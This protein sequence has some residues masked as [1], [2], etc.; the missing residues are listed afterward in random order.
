MG[1]R[2]AAGDLMA[3]DSHETAARARKL[4]SEA[5]ETG[6]DF[7][8]RAGER[9]RSSVDDTR[10]RTARELRSVANALRGRGGALDLSH[11]SML[12]PYVER[13]AHQMDRAGTF[14][15]THSLDDLAHNVRTFARRRPALFLGGCFAAGVLAARFLR[16]SS[17]SASHP[18]S[19]RRPPVGGPSIAY[20]SGSPQRVG[21]TAYQAGA[22]YS[23]PMRGTR[24]TVGDRLNLDN[25]PDAYGDDFDAY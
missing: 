14:L 11:D 8:S 5:K 7:A 2:L 12:G 19:S 4:M 18:P 20:P 1:Q 13:V 6:R 16:A 15:E 9:A 23:G 21:D 17:G 24:G 10:Q 25:M 22:M 3:M